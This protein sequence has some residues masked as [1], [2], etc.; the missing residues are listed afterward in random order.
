MGS[1]EVKPTWSSDTPQEAS[2]LG[3]SESK[4]DNSWKSDPRIQV[5]VPER[6]QQLNAVNE[7]RKSLRKS[8]SSGYCNS[9]NS[10]MPVWNRHWPNDGI[11]V[12]P[13]IC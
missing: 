13:A 1:R 7:G 12:G 3:D 5:L 10:S 2:T 4:V 6:V 9:T 8:K 11:L